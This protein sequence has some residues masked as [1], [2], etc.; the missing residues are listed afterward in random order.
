LDDAGAKV[1]ALHQYLVGLR[2]R[3]PWLHAAST[4]AL[5]LDNRHYVYRTSRAQDALLV[6]LNI[7]DRPMHLV[8]PELGVARAEVLAGSSAPPQEVVDS[9]VVEA[10]G[11]RILRP[12]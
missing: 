7:D 12:S 2:R 5:R 9:V 6:A 8:L 3:H 10:H 1:W 4:T 11:W